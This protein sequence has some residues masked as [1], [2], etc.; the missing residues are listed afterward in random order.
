MKEKSEQADR[1]VKLYG[2]D[3]NRPYP[4]EELPVAE[5]LMPLQKHP[6]ERSFT[7]KIGGTE[8]TVNACFREDGR[9]LLTYLSQLILHGVNPN[10]F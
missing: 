4:Y 1:I 9:D 7:E 8:Y 6:P 3:E 10:H 2:K 5:N